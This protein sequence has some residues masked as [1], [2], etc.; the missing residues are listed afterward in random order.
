MALYYEQI[1]SDN[2]S[3]NNSGSHTHVFDGITYYMPNGV[4]K[5]LGTYD[6]VFSHNGYYPLYHTEEYA[7]ANS[8]STTSHSHTFGSVTY[9]MPN[10]VTNYH[11]DYVDTTSTPPC[12]PPL[13]PFKSMDL[14]QTI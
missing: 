3:P 9:Y 7:N 4:T 2:N 12:I 13:P 10:G 1:Y 8:P 14:F 6:N 5:Y 11:G